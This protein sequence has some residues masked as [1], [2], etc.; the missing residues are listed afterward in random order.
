MEGDRD[1]CIGA[2]MND[3]LAKPFGPDAMVDILEKWLE[4]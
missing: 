3:Y 1:H 4:P 2:G